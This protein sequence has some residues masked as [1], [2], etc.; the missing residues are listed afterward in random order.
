MEGL[1]LHR[2]ASEP[3]FRV[4]EMRKK[5]V[6]PSFVLVAVTD[7]N[8]ISRRWWHGGLL[9]FISGFLLA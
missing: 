5:F 9:P 1:S 6:E 3:S 4:L 7:K 8:L 2:T